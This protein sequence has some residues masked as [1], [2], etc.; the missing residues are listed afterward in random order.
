M[1]FFFHTFAPDMNTPHA[2]SK[3]ELSQLYA[4]ELTLGA[5]LNRLR[6]W[7]HHNSALMHDLHEAN[8]HDGDRLFTPRQVEIIFRHLGEP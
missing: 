8:Y 7:L 4:P 2:M 5:A 3:K 6:Q 1:S